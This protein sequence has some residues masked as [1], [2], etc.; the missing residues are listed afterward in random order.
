MSAKE[1]RERRREEG[2]I[3][4]RRLAANAPRPHSFA[5]VKGVC[6][7]RQSHYN[8]NWAKG[9]AAFVTAINSVMET[10]PHDSSITVVSRGIDGLTS[11]NTAMKSF[12]EMWNGRV[13]LQIVFQY[14]LIIDT[15]DH[16]RL[17]PFRGLGL[18]IAFTGDELLDYL[19][20]RVISP[21]VTRLVD[22]WREVNSQ[23]GSGR[24]LRGR[25]KL[26]AEDYCP[27]TRA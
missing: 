3:I 7:T 1:N 24:G 16:P 11:S 23:K 26:P 12:L 6:E 18:V 17:T 2:R 19:S 22:I 13:K 8:T 20:G 25:N 9:K 4:G 27:A 10:V 15:T 21:D 14:Y 5:W